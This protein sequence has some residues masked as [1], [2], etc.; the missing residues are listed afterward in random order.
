[1]KIREVTECDR[2][3]F[4][5]L[6]N[7]SKVKR[8]NVSPVMYPNSDEVPYQRIIEDDF[9]ITQGIVAIVKSEA[10]DGT[11][12][13]RVCAIH[14]RARRKG[15][16]TFACSEINNVVDSKI[17]DKLIAC[18]DKSN[19]EAISRMEKL[20]LTHSGYRTPPNEHIKIFHLKK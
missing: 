7:D 8:Y 1:M 15:L 4:E 3:L 5:E 2:P 18:I 19:Y 13:E 14:K 20:G 17:R 10:Y 16:A 6:S 9:G 11:F 12:Y